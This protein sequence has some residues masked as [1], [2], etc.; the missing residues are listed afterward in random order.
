[1]RAPGARRRPRRAARSSRG[2]APAGA[3]SRGRARPRSSR[4]G[5][6]LGFAR[7][8]GEAV[9]KAASSRASASARGARGAWSCSAA[10]LCR[11][12]RHERAQRLLRGRRARPAGE[13]RDD[14]GL[15]IGVGPRLCRATV[16][17]AREPTPPAAR[18]PG[19]ALRPRPRRVSR[20]EAADREA[21]PRVVA[22]PRGRHGV[23]TATGRSSGLT[24]SVSQRAR[25]DPGGEA[26]SAMAASIAAARAG[27]RR[28]CPWPR[29]R[30][31]RR[32]LS[33]A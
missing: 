18:A 7:W 21:C 15:Q 5:P 6:A 2:S 8:Y 33:A 20:G 3:A 27:L 9:S 11:V 30:G 19:R 32:R 28:R 1:M 12:A 14:G 17:S 25:R 31:G 24:K 23:A 13:G 16:C 29:A 4:G 26:S 10:R 22:L